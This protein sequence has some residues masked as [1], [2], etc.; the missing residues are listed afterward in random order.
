[1]K[2]CHHC[3]YE[4]VSEA[5]KPGFK[6]VCEKCSSYVHCCVNCKHHNPSL[7]NQCAIPTTDYVGDRTGANFC[8]DFEFKDAHADG[9]DDQSKARNKLDALFGDE[10]DS[11]G[12]DPL[13]QFKNL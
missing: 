5:K 3:Q 11:D 4:W 2:V 10:S 7:H 1:M 12:P 8:E 13:D 6:E 9:G